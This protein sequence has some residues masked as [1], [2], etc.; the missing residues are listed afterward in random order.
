M[1]KRF[2]FL[3]FL[4]AVLLLP[5]CDKKPE[6]PVLSTGDITDIA[7]TSATINGVI[8]D[9]GGAAII[10]SGICWNTL[11]NPT[12]DD[13]YI[14]GSASGS[15]ITSQ[16]TG[17]QPKTTYFARAFALNSGGTGYGESKSF[18]TLGDT[19][20][21]TTVNANEI[22]TRTATLNGTVNPHFLS[23]RVVFEWGVTTDYGNTTSVVQ[24]PLTGNGDVSVNA[25]ITNLSAGTTYHFRVKADNSLGV[26]YGSDL[27]FKTLGGIPEI[28]LP[29]VSEV[30]LNTAKL[31]GSVNPDYLPTS[32][33]FEWG[34]TSAYGNVINIPGNL[35]ANTSAN[36]VASLLGLT[37]ETKYHYRIVAINELGTKR[38]D[39]M[40]FS[41]YSV[42]DIDNNYYHSVNIGNQTWLSENLKATRFN[43]GKAI[44]Q[45]TNQTE[46]ESPTT[47][48]AYCWYNN[49]SDYKDLYGALYNYWVINPSAN[50]F[51]N[52]CPS[53]W[54]VPNV[55]EWSVLITYLKNNGYTSGGA[56]NIAKSLAGNKGWNNDVTT[57]SVGNNLGANNASGFSAYG[58]G[59]RANS[60]QG[61]IQM[62]IRGSW[63][64]N[65]DDFSG[66][67]SYS[68]TDIFNY[69]SI[70]RQA[71]N[72][73]TA[74]LS[75]RCI[76]DH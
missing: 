54:H 16:I 59:I 44:P 64:A 74:G 51:R 12:T 9:D 3:I 55:S 10:A 76:K 29:E 60:P 31:T 42:M 5:S 48:Y 4:I 24:N 39:D 38:T 53:G 43:N 40:T 49:S 56:D 72:Y 46:W 17:L 67:Y 26:S 32:V 8:S 27:T 58:G 1:K 65:P 23:A 7:T 18:T 6:P 22:T 19:P 20:A 47:G 13:N 62:G 2:T 68:C 70:V 57:G 37:P 45:I 69:E 61:F 66:G 36:I 11:D 14:N 63:W 71:N 25:D 30:T 33:F 52:V 73:S 28:T 35:T 34:S 41:T 15:L 50:A 21:P 75:I